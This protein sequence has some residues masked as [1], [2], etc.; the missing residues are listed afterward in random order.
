MKPGDHV[1]VLVMRE[2]DTYRTAT[3]KSMYTWCVV[4]ILDRS[5]VGTTTV[6]EHII[7]IT[8]S[9]EDQHV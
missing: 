1:R 4:V 2:P 7:P 8:E 9:Q 5:G 6:R 3:I